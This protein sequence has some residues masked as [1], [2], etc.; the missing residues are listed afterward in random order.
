VKLSE[1]LSQLDRVQNTRLFKV[2]ASCLILVLAVGGYVSY[3]VAVH[4]PA[5]GSSAVTSRGAGDGTRASRAE[6]RNSRDAKADVGADAGKGAGGKSGA[7]SGVVDKASEDAAEAGQ[8]ALEESQRIFQ[9]IVS[10]QSDPTSVGVGISVAAVLLLS[11]V[12]LG[13]GL[14]ALALLAVTASVVYPL[15]LFA[16]TRNFARLLAGLVALTGSFVVLMRLLQVLFSGSGAVWA[17]ARNVLTEAVRMKVTVI[18]IVL[19]IFGLAALP[20]TLEASSPLRYRVQTFLQYGTGGSFWIIAVLTLVFSASTVA[21]EQRNKTIWQ[22]MTKPVASWQFL[23]GKWLG[24]IGLNAVLLAVC[25]SGVFLFTEHLRGQAAVGERE[26]YQTM[27]G[28]PSED[29]M[30]LETR[31]LRSNVVVEA[32]PPRIL[33]EQFKQNIDL[34]IENEKKSNPAFDTSPATV[35]K[36]SEEL[37]KSI[38]QQYR[39]LD[40]GKDQLFVFAGLGEAKRSGLPLTFKYR[41]DSGANMPDRIYRMTFR[42]RDSDPIV[43]ETGL[44]Y[45]H[46]LLLLPS[47]IDDDGLLEVQ[48]LNS[49]LF[50]GTPNQES[51]TFPAGGLEVS[52]SVGS[53]RLNFVRVISVLWVKLAFL[54]ML[55]IW[56]STFLSFPVACLVAFGSFLAAE[57]AGFLAE[58]LENYASVDDKG[59]VLPVAVVV[60]AIGQVVANTFKVYADLQPTTKLVDGTQLSWGSVGRGV[61]VLGSTSLLLF[62]VSVLIFRKRELAT[63]SG[64]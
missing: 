39:S 4:A 42:F 59:N 37:Y 60:N 8:N 19:L 58:S 26:P 30:I 29:R 31:V 10:A 62:G 56:A 35:K 1:R 27:G 49:D 15:H 44:G 11:V 18:F 25:G 6:E 16:P 22:T 17:V 14:T 38:V 7:K 57:S 53:Y 3:V 41:I 23:L 24:V 52:Y 63:Y 13:L 54:S 48:V 12:W 34:R 5:D 28:G 21:F 46:T 45:S 32:E 2:I 40:P 47:V 9:S 61:L 55:A 20:S 36:L 33:P 51:A 50:A 64:Q 43:N